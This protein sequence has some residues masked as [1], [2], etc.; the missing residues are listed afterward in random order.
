MNTHISIL[1]PDRF[2]GQAPDIWPVD[3]Q[4][5]GTVGVVYHFKRNYK[6]R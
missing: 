1:Y 4:F 5:N 2:N 3:I 6:R